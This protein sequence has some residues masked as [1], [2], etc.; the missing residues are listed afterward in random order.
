ML[1][2]RYNPATDTE[3][4]QRLTPGPWS[5]EPLQGAK[6]AGTEWAVEA[7]DPVEA[8]ASLGL[9]LTDAVVQYQVNT[10]PFGAPEVEL[11][12]PRDPRHLY[13]V[14]RDAF[15]DRWAREGHPP[16]DFLTLAT[17]PLAVPPVSGV[18]LVD[19]A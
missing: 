6:L 10:D 3:E 19:G 9:T 18:A 11:S 14:F 7:P 17:G 8:L 16:E 12:W 1:V 5:T 4:I 2:T 13:R 15:D